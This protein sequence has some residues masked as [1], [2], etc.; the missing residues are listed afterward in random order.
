MQWFYTIGGGAVLPAVVSQCST[1]GF[2]GGVSGVSRCVAAVLFQRRSG[3]GNGG[4]VA[5]L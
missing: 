3:G 4:A 2:P 5:G 1:G